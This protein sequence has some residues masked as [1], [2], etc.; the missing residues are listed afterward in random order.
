[1]FSNAR[2]RTWPSRLASSSQALGTRMSSAPPSASARAASGNSRS[3][4][5]MAPTATV[6]AE[7]SRST[8]G[9]SS[10]GTSACSGRSKL[11]VCTFA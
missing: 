2:A 11:H 8:T 10:P 6:P 7:V 3:K 4:Q 5:I 1:M 9:Y